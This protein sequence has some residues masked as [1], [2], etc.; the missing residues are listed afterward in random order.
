MADDPKAGAQQAI[1]D[2][3]ALR[4]LQEEQREKMKGNPTPTQEENDLHKLGV[5]TAEKEPDGSESPPFSQDK[6]AADR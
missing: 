5:D 3:A 6:A 2:A 4:E 1:D